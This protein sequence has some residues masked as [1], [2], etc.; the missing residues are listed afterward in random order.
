[1]QYT[2][3]KFLS[4]FG[5]NNCFSYCSSES[6]EYICRKYIKIC[7]LY[8]SKNIQRVPYWKIL[9]IKPMNKLKYVTY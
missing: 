8:I 9:K 6:Y 5:Q 2:L 3:R 1:M 7:N 4:K